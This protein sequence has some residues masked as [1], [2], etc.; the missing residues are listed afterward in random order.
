[1]SPMGIMSAAETTPTAGGQITDDAALWRRLRGVI[2]EDFRASPIYRTK[3]AGPTPEP[4]RIYPADL[5]PPN[6]DR[7][8]ALA[9]R[10]WRYGQERIVLEPGEIPW[11]RIAPSRH[12]ADRLHRFD[13]LSHL[14]SRDDQHDWARDLVDHWCEEFG[15]FNP[16]AW[17]IGTTADRVWNWLKAGP[18]LFETGTEEQC[19]TRRSVL[20]RQV[21]HLH[22]SLA[23]SPDALARWR[24]AAVLVVAAMA[25]GEGEQRLEEALARF[26]MEMTAQILP[27]GGHVSRSPERLLHALIDVLTV[28]DLFERSARSAPDFLDRWIR[29]MAPMLG[30]FIAGDGGLVPFNGG[31]ESR[32]ELVTS[33]LEKADQPRRNFMFAMKSGFQ[34]L[35]AGDTRVLLD[36]GAGPELPFGDFAHAGCLSFDLHDG[37]TRLVTSCGGSRDV[38]PRWQDSVRSTRAHSSLSLAGLEIGRWETN[39]ET[40]LEYLI[41]PEGIAAKR[42]EEESRDVWLE[43]QHGGW[44]DRYGLIH[45][46]RLFLTSDGQRLVGEDTLVRPISQGPAEYLTPIPFEIRFH[47]HPDVRPEPAGDAFLLVPKSGRIWRF[48]TSH[49]DIRLEK[50]VYVG[51]GRLEATHQI[52]LSGRA[53]P[54][55]DGASPPNCIKWAFLRER[56][57]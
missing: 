18:A 6:A 37:A 26:D 23:A 16:F 15:R 55:G 29:R 39:E 36:A 28:K 56:I 41:G 22:A 10:R 50:S 32:G 8:E 53:D 45:K 1:M 48:R 24:G 44:R 2:G 17:R 9:L 5:S 47:L 25:Y 14:M 57:A 12:F 30:F 21:R 27:D 38:S 49:D 51:R 40:R 54:A 19:E 52:V 34:K 42:L 4:F 33:A 3:L 20:A 11:A 35:A 46:R 13:W 43:V 31:S 7:A